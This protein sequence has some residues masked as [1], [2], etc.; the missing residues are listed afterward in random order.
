MVS[1]PEAVVRAALKAVQQANFV[2]FDSLLSPEIIYRDPSRELR[3]RDAFDRLVEQSH[4]GASEMTWETRRI[5]AEGGIVFTE[6]TDSFRHHGRDF[7]V[8]IVGVF[9]VGEDGRIA[10]WREYFD[11]SPFRSRL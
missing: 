7:T 8:D 10:E 1:S 6:R 3:G 4:D 11:P 2:A 9:V 5:A